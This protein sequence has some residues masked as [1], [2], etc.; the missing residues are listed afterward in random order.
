LFTISSDHK[1]L[2]RVEKKHTQNYRVDT[3][4]STVLS[5]HA[6]EVNSSINKKILICSSTLVDN[7]LLRKVNPTQYRYSKVWE[8]E[9]ESISGN[10]CAGINDNIL[11]FTY[12][13]EL[14]SAF[15]TGYLFTNRED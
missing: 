12:R 9:R 5:T 1:L 13:E 11:A 10:R 15:S 3:L 14:Q 2:S 8:S 7:E 4:L 6:L